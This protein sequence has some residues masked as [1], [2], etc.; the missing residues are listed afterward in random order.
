[1]SYLPTKVWV[2]P[3]LLFKKK[4]KIVLFNILESEDLYDDFES[5]APVP[6]S[7]TWSCT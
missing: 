7:G 6:V 2:L 3:K 5:L 1:M 4:I